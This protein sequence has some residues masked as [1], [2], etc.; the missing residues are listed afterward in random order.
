MAS[1]YLLAVQLYTNTD[2]EKIRKQLTNFYCWPSLGRILKRPNKLIKKG[3]SSIR[4]AILSLTVFNESAYS[5]LQT[6]NTPWFTG[7]LRLRTDICSDLLAPPHLK[8]HFKHCTALHS[9]SR[10]SAFFSI[11][12]NKKNEELGSLHGACRNQKIFTQRQGRLDKMRACGRGICRGVWLWL[13]RVCDMPH[14]TCDFSQL[15]G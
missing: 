9:T 11:L 10:F 3:I 2:R 8:N 14:R 6:L 12:A 5:E 1:H 7:L 15:F 4:A 13:V